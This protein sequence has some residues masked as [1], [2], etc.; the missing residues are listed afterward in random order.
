M[1]YEEVLEHLLAPTHRAQ[2]STHMSRYRR[3]ARDE[4]HSRH[5]HD[6]ARMHANTLQR[7]RERLPERG[8]CG[9]RR[10]GGEGRPDGELMHSAHH[11]GTGGG[12]VRGVLGE[13]RREAR[14][15]LPRP[16]RPSAHAGNLW[17]SPV[18]DHNR[19]LVL[20]PSSRSP[21]G[22]AVL[23]DPEAH[24]RHRGAQGPQ[25]RQMQR[26]R[27]A[28]GLAVA[29]RAGGCGRPRASFRGCPAGRR[30]EEEGERR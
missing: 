26:R 18:A 13:L 21:Y 20:P 7:R 15:A 11:H 16:P 30:E 27:T 19:R 17:R 5:E 14:G 24:T 3:S 25:N 9:G 29:A 22:D 2:D 8:C 28:V 4:R 23:G 10:E 6:I 12:A 1:V